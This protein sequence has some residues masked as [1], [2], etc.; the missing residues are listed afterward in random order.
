MHFDGEKVRTSFTLT[1]DGERW[2]GTLYYFVKEF[3]EA[4][5]E[6]V[7]TE[8]KDWLQGKAASTEWGQPN[9]MNPNVEHDQRPTMSWIEASMEDDPWN[10]D[11][12]GR[13]NPGPPALGSVLE[14]FAAGP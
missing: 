9:F 11:W 13:S 12:Y 7:R 4:N 1:K 6:A 14:G 8:I 3:N 10:F 5:M 2:P